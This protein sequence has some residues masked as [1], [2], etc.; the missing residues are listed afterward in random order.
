MV[1]MIVF[2]AVVF[3]V[4]LAV[5][6]KGSDWLL[7][8]AERIGLAFG[9]SP[10]IVGV[11]IIGF[12]TSLPELAS[13]IAGVLG[14]ARELVVANVVGSNIANILLIAGMAAVAGGRLEVGKNLVDLDIPMLAIAT[15][16]LLGVSYDGVVT[17]PE[18]LFLLVAFSVY[19]IYTFLHEDE[20]KKRAEETIAVYEDGHVPHRLSSRDIVLLVVGLVMLVVGARYMVQ[21]VLA[22]SGIIGIGVGAISLV[23]VAVGTSL[24]E[25]VVSIRA[26][27]SGKADVSLGNIF[28]SNVF[29]A[30]FVVGIPGLIAPLVV[31]AQT[32]TIGLAVMIGATVLFIISTLSNQVYK[33]EGAMYIILYALFLGKLASLL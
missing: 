14:G 31:D 20:E 10:F 16:F 23:A 13:S 4:S 27:L 24:P 1:H 6:V 11:V 7:A 5:L 9:L 12:G 28:G 19:L 17:R 3:V 22:L 18:A 30:L 29:N 2:W 26:G 25:L 33:Y 21:A 32:A 8:S 15:A